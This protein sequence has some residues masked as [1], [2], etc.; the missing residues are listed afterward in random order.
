M[1][2]I[3]AD[4]RID[5]LMERYCKECDKRKGMKNGKRQFIYEIG[6]A[7]CRACEVDDVKAE[8]EEAPT[9]DAVPVVRCEDGEER[10]MRLVDVDEIMSKIVSAVS[11][12]N[13]KLET[14]M[15]PSVDYLTGLRRGLIDAYLLLNGLTVTTKE[16]ELLSKLRSK[17]EDKI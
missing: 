10:K 2:L 9:I 12:I 1:R 6:E 15:S 14:A 17:D 11:E 8:L 13:N 16:S 5:D 7:P 3:D 4:A